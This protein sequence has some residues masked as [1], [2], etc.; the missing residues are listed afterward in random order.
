LR[1]QGFFQIFRENIHTGRSDDD[2]FS[3]AFELQAAIL[4]RLRDVS[5]SKPSVGFGN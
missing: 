2:V 1:S 3:A 4:V 5:R